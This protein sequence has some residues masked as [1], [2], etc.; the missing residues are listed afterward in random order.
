MRS[1]ICEENKKRPA[2][3]RKVWG[4]KTAKS[5]RSQNTSAFTSNN[6]MH[7]FYFPGLENNKE[8]PLQS[9]KEDMVASEKIGVS[10]KVSGEL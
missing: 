6:F 7:D 3:Q 4:Q 2:N 10:R 8:C 9:A 5:E 1:S